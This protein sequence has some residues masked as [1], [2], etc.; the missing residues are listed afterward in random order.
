MRLAEHERNR[1]YG[2][3]IRTGFGQARGEL[4][5]YTDSDNQFDLSDLEHFMPLI[6]EYDAVVGFRVYRYDS[7]VRSMLS[8]IYNLIV[9]ILFRVRVRDV[10][11]AFKLFRREVINAI[12]IESDDFFVDAELVAKTRRWNFRILEKGVR[13]YPRVAGETTVR[14]S[15][16]PGTLRRIAIMWKRIHF[17]GRR[18]LEWPR[19]VDRAGAIRGGTKCF[20]SAS[21]STSESSPH[22]WSTAF[23]R[24][25]PGFRSSTGGFR[26]AGRSSPPSSSGTGGSGAVD[27]RHPRRRLRHGPDAGRPRAAS[28]RSR[29]STTSPRRSSARARGR[30]RLHCAPADALP[31]AD[32]QYDLLTLLDVIEHI[33]DDR[34]ALVESRRVL[35]PGGT[36]LIMVPAYTWMWGRQDEIAHHKRRYTRP[37][38]VSLLA[39]SGFEVLRATYFNTLLFPPIAAIRLARR[40]IGDDAETSDFEL[41][42]PGPLNTLL[43]R[44]FSFEARLLDRVRFPFGVS[45]L[46]IARRPAVGRG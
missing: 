17:P 28:G 46:V 1:G 25:T 36:V 3:A 40:V 43:A 20:R 15:D 26:V 11:C 16:I 33:D 24:S 19:G 10:D 4:L 27:R 13:H 5:F 7:V 39:D 22:R 42:R 34:A 8:W 41:S 23:T 38:L 12:V 30:S 35:K 9:R 21:Q 29:A 2:A 44:A 18:H 31:F 14:A 6:R 45:V 32:A 37:R